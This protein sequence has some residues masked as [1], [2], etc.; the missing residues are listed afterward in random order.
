M[1]IKRKDGLTI[2]AAKEELKGIGVSL[3]WRHSWREFEVN[4]I[5]DHPR[6]AYF[7][8]DLH[9]ALCTGRLMAAQRIS[10]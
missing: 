1:S 4:I 2:R 3:I 8:E 6:A 7:T 10:R 9:D 5:G